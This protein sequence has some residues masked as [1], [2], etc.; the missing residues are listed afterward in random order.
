MDSCRAGV[1]TRVKGGRKGPT[2]AIDWDQSMDAEGVAILNSSA[3]GE[4]A[5]ESDR[6]RA[7][8]FTRFFAS[9]LIGAADRNGDG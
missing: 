6:L 1:V 9:A 4:D 2:F 3:A 5:Q 8:F 7:S